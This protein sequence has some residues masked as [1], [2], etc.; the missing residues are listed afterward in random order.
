MSEYPSTQPF[1]PHGPQVP[2]HTVTPNPTAQTQQSVPGSAPDYSP[3]RGEYAPGGGEYVARPKSMA[4]AVVLS[5]L[6]GPFGV[7]YAT[8]GTRQ[9]RWAVAWLIGSVVLMFAVGLP[10]APILAVSVIWSVVAV[11]SHNT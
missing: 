8:F 10:L 7:I 11:R 9:Y 5:I 4:K 1:G 2:A 6:L 3:Q